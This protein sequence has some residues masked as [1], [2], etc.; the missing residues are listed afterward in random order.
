[1]AAAAARAENLDNGFGAMSQFDDNGN[2]NGIAD[3]D[4]DDADG[5][6]QYACECRVSF[7]EI[8]NEEVRVSKQSVT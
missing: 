1:M 5:S 6:S 4:D 2:G 7:L 8:H 3:N